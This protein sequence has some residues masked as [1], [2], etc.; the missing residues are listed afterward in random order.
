MAIGPNHPGDKSR[1][2]AA[3]SRPGDHRGPTPHGLLQPDESHKL[4][5]QAKDA[6]GLDHEIDQV[7]NVLRSRREATHREGA[8]HPAPPQPDNL[9][10][11]LADTQPQPPPRPQGQAP[12]LSSILGARP[13]RTTP[14]V[15]SHEYEAA[16]RAAMMLA[17][18]RA[19][20][21]RSRAGIQPPPSVKPRSR[22]DM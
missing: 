5:T 13:Q 14:G 3:K 4:N 15:P 18:Q 12:D 2:A 10:I 19:Q 1:R 21:I 16:L 22:Y 8:R 6:G 20:S 7:A 9:D 11:E 17:Q